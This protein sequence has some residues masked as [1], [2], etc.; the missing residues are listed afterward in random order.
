M[1]SAAIRSFDYRAETRGL[2]VT[3]TTGRSYLYAN[4]PH[5]SSWLSPLTY[6]SFS[7]PNRS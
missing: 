2:L 4:V 7:P 5:A 1:T 3:F 6:V